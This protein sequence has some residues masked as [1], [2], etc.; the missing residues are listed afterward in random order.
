MNYKIHFVKGVDDDITTA[1]Q[2]YESK[3]KGLGEKFVAD[4][5]TTAVYIESNPFANQIRKK[6][7]R[8]AY[9]K[10]FPFIIVYEVEKKNI[11]VYAL[12]HAK[13]KPQRF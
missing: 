10:K 6:S 7:N 8:H 2:W 9:L 3:V 1:A 4:W 12:V 5:E 11:Y 13:Q